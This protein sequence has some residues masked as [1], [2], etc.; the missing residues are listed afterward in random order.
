MTAARPG[1]EGDAA[2]PAVLEQQVRRMLADPR[3]K[4][5]IDEFR[6]AVAV[7]AQS[8]DAR[9]ESR[10]LFPDFDDNLREAFQ[11]ET[12]LFLREHQLARIAASWSC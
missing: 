8:A 10:R 12:E 5:L 11:Q 7:S 2:E 9:A 6:R 3:S 1:G 4:S